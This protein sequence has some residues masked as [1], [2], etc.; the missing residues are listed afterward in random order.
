MSGLKLIQAKCSSI[1]YEESLISYSTI[2]WDCDGVV[3][4]SNKIKTNAFRSVSLP[5]GEEASSALVEFHVQNGGMSRYAKFE[6]F[7]D[8][9]LPAYLPEPFFEDKSAFLRC[10][11]SEFAET[12][13]AALVKCE[14]APGLRE[15]RQ[16]MQNVCWLIVSGGDQE[17]LREVFD[18]RGIADYF[19]G[20]IYG[21]PKDK[22]S[23]VAELL[24]SK[25]VHLPCLFVGDSRLDH[26]V[27]SA[28]G[29]EFIFVNQWTEFSDWWMYC[30]R[31]NIRYVLGIRDILD[32]KIFT[33]VR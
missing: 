14:I 6:Y 32:L 28:F 15:L 20:G 12:V 26:E 23:I 8:T 11:L 21:S 29:F 13:K 16:S 4:N 27:A 7:V 17:E 2:M 10:L 24:E 1:Q 25:H 18:Q 31:N 19:D 33:K 5:F 22:Y 30:Q 3:L 9:I